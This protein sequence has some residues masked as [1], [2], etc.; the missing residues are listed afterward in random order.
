MKFEWDSK[1]ADENL[2]KHG[3]TFEEAASAFFDPN[4]VET[5]DATHSNHEQRWV[6]VAMSVYARAVLVVH[7][8]RDA[9]AE[10]ITRIISARKANK[11]ERQVYFGER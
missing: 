5:P 11:K 1:K 9:N 10:E 7:T 8:E 2:R 4:G 3:V 6:R